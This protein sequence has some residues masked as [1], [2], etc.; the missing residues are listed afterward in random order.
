MK[1]TLNLRWVLEQMG[2]EDID[3]AIDDLGM[4]KAH[5]YAFSSRSGEFLAFE[6]KD[7]D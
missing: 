2:I 6:E 1:Y 4:G 5:I 7:D 3:K